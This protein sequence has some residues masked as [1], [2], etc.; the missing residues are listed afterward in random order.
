[1]PDPIELTAEQKLEPVSEQVVLYLCALL[2]GISTDNGYPINVSVE[3]LDPSGNPRGAPNKDGMIVVEEEFPDPAFDVTPGHLDGFRL[4]V[5]L[6]CTVRNNR[7]LSDR[8]WATVINR[9]IAHVQMRLREDENLGGYTTLGVNL[10]K[11]TGSQIYGLPA[12][13]Q[14]IDFVCW[15][16]RKD[17]FTA[18]K[19]MT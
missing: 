1:M 3:R 15:T 13:N 18:Y 9:L 5:N 10:Q 7:K 2:S 14:P 12:F 4:R 11:A 16:K 17:P 6:Y 8:D 19:D